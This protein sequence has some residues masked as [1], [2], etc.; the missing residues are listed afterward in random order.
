MTIGAITNCDYL[1]IASSRDG[2]L[3]PKLG[4]QL[5]IVSI[6]LAL[7]DSLESEREETFNDV[8]SVVEQLSLHNI[9]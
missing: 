6:C 2:V 1:V 5:Y 9:E 7:S 8:L 3:Q 4:H